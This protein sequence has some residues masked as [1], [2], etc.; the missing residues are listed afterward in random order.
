MKRV[1]SI[2]DGFAAEREQAPSPQ[3]S[4]HFSSRPQVCAF[5]PKLKRNRSLQYSKG[6]KQP[7][8]RVATRHCV[9]LQCFLRDTCQ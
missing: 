7:Y 6:D 9:Q 3:W 8:S 2:N 4:L 5:K 1:S